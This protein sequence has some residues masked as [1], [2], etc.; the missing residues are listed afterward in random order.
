M[1]TNAPSTTWLARSRMKLRR[2]R[3][4]YWLDACV[5]ATVV[6]EKVTPA[7]V[8]IE[9]AI[10]ESI[11]RELPALAPK[12]RGQR[13]SASASTRADSSTIP[14]ASAMAPS[15]IAPGTNQRLPRS[16]AQSA[17]ILP[18]IGRR[19]RAGP[20]PWRRRVVE[21]HA[22]RLVGDSHRACECAEPARESPQVGRPHRRHAVQH[23][24]RG[25]MRG[26]VQK[27]RARA[28]REDLRPPPVAGADAALDQGAGEEPVDDGG[29]GRS[30]GERA[31]G[32]FGER[33]A[34]R[35]GDLL[36]DEELRGAQPRIAL[37]P[38]RSQPELA[39]DPSQGVER[40][41]SGG[42]RARLVLS[43][44]ARIGSNG[45]GS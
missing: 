7:T 41:A 42:R 38:R 6:M 34:R 21:E 31:R 43:T 36:E 11:E 18:R 8:I 12:T 20:A 23:A 16:C 35:G 33:E 1:P 44:R 28:G 29:H 37:P 2:M 4:V 26:A 14:T 19:P 24:P 39:H 32:E 13:A 17:A 10:A 22:R 45:H 5:T 40:L 15:T 9:P 27:P 3:G 30:I 25:R